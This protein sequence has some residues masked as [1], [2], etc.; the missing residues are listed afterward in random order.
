M[1]TSILKRNTLIVVQNLTQMTQ[2]VDD[3]KMILWV[4]PTQ[5]SG[6]KYSQKERSTWYSGITVCSID[7]RDKVCTED[8]WL[9]LLDEADCYLGSDDR[10]EWVGNISSE[11]LYALTG[12]VKI[13]HVE[14]KVFPIYYGKTTRLELIHE[15]PTYK[16]VYSDFEYY[17]DDIG[18]FY[19]LKEALYTAEKRNELIVE[20]TIK[21]LSWRKAIVFTEHIEHAKQLAQSF[22]NRWIRTY[23]LIWEVSKDERE[24]IRQEAKEYNGEVILVGS[25]KILG[26]G[27]DL[28]ELSLAVLTTAEKFQSSCLQYVWRIVRKFP[29]KPQPIF[30]DIVDHLTNILNNQARHRVQTYK[31]NFPE[32]KV[33]NY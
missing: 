1:L 2:M 25:V 10:R 33:I 27:F 13:N 5:V 14:D 29:R 11:Y 12:T 7:S 23:I 28:P 30:I 3:V 17:L 19:K 22:T 6:K 20:T 9:V 8:Y 26:R 32:W 18:E 15:T 24:R 16:Q 4:T 31:R 21:H